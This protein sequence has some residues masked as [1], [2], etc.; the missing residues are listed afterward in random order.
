MKK[1]Q[2]V[3]PTLGA[4]LQG[5]LPSIDFLTF[6]SGTRE[7][8]RSKNTRRELFN[9]LPPPGP[10]GEKLKK[11]VWGFFQK[12]S[13]Q[14]GLPSGGDFFDSSPSDRA[15]RKKAPLRELFSS[16][17]FFPSLPWNPGKEKTPLMR[18]ACLGTFR[19]TSLRGRFFLLFPL[20]DPGKGE[21]SFPSK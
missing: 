4:P 1:A 21:K 16:E 13:F 14:K 15:R 9:L 6:P 3:P 18:K 10:G 17:C 5:G 7:R 2:R 8:E 11:P 19:G 12:D 20:L